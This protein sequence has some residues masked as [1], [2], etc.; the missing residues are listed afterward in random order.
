MRIAIID[1]KR[2]KPNKCTLECI[3]VCPINRAGDKCVFL[4][5]D[6][7]STIDE[8]LCIGCSLCVKKCPYKALNVVNTP[9]KLTESP[10]H[11]FGA[12]QFTLFR[13]PFPIKGE[14]V[15]LLGPNGTGKTTT[16]NILSGEMK[17]NLGTEKEAE[18]KE[19]IKIFRGTELQGFLEN[20]EKQKLKAVIKPQKVD[21]LAAVKGTVK[22]VLKKHDERKMLKEVVEKLELKNC[23]DRE[24]SKLSGGELQRVAIAIAY[25][26]KADI[27]YIDEPSSYLDVYQRLEVAKLIREMAKDAAV[28]VVEHDLATLDFLADRIHT[29]YGS[30]GAFG[31]VSK[32]YN[33]R[34]GIN[35]FL[36]GFI[37]EDNIR[38]RED[39]INFVVVGRERNATKET[40]LEFN[41]L[42]KKLG[43]FSLEISSGFVKKGEVIG[44]FGANAL[45]KTTFARILAGEIKPDE[46]EI[47]SA[48]RISYKPQYITTDFSGTVAELLETVSNNIYSDDYK[49]LILRP[50]GVER[51]LESYVTDLSGGELQRVA[52]AVCLSKEAD[53]YL[54]DEPSAYLDVEQ[55]LAVAKAIQKVCETRN[56]SALVIDHDLLFLNYLSDR[57]IVFIG[58]SGKDGYAEQC[59]VQAGYNK[60]L[61]EVNVTFRKDPQTG[62]PRA[63]KPGSQKDQEQKEKGKYFYAD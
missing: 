13:L 11:R 22:E 32:P 5:D 33:T 31:V 62:R 37:K 25:L 27:Y 24:L 17:P 10:I 36:D 26:R 28:M 60:F 49:G 8:D 40:V 21:I 51:L 48:A 43:D 3:N 16:L 55:R 1:K 30:P 38:I 56:C 2:C 29:F 53:I 61:K 57:A 44:V 12:N 9:E 15:G 6:S 7:K 23:L 47:S 58:E 52:I 41:N 45:G 39:S 20:L 63:N 46:G 54:L 59:E 50:L 18:V 42:K 14:V 4:G 34:V 35:A 19:L